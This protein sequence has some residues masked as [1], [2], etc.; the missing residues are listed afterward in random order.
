MVL[1]FEAEEE[2]FDGWGRPWQTVRRRKREEIDLIVCGWVYGFICKMFMWHP[3]IGGCKTLVLHAILIE[4]NL[5]RN[6]QEDGGGL[7]ERK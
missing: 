7:M 3:Q 5:K 6:R 4:F 1:T 2:R